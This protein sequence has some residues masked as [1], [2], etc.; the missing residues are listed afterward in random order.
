MFIFPALYSAIP[1]QITCNFQIILYV[2]AFLV[3]NHIAN[4]EMG[5]NSA[6]SKLMFAKFLCDYSKRKS[7]VFI[8]CFNSPKF[9]GRRLLK[10]RKKECEQ[11]VLKWTYISHLKWEVLKALFIPLLLNVTTEMWKIFTIYLNI[12]S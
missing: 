6:I 4:L 12:V 2:Y 9:L 5:E 11:G 1:H 10:L 7:N 8:Q 3:F